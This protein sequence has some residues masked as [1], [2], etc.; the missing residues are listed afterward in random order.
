MST[1]LS[2]KFR[3]LLTKATLLDT[4]TD[5][6]AYDKLQG[7]Y[8]ALQQESEYDDDALDEEDL[9]LP[10]WEN[11]IYSEHGKYGLRAS[12]WTPAVPA[13]Y[14][15][16]ECVD[17]SNV[18]RVIQDG[19]VGMIEVAHEVYEIFKAEYDA[20]TEFA[21]GK[22]IVVKNKEQYYSR[23]GRISPT[24]FDEIRVPVCAGW[25][26]VKKEGIWGYL[27]GNLEF[28][29]SESDAH[30]FL[31][32]CDCLGGEWIQVEDIDFRP[33]TRQD[34]VTCDAEENKLTES[35]AN[36]DE[37]TAYKRRAQV[38]L[39]NHE[40]QVMENDGKYGA[41]DFLGYAVIPPVYDEIVIT[42]H[43]VP[44]IYGKQNGLWAMLHPHDGETI[45][46]SEEL[47]KMVFAENWLI[48]KVKG[49]YGIYNSLGGAWMLAPVYDDFR[50]KERHRCIVTQ[51]GNQYGFF[52][53]EFN[54]PPVYDGVLLGTNLSFV[55]VLKNGAVGYLDAAGEWTDD[56]AKAHVFTKCWEL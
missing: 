5:A 52:D 35:K 28:S 19:K 26:R 54:I 22:Y 33:V 43:A 16:V 27:D 55:R 30:E 25:I 31:I 46:V 17:E 39:P 44:Y 7:E 21:Q 2:D 24:S 45:F 20:I 11:L 32:P 47:P 6:D 41:V 4:C 53:G 29:S 1:T 9:M 38:L 8:L 18:Y 15:S 13:I 49:K 48:A 50:I 51:Q 56:I 23:E 34:I 40:Y 3:A 37:W 42:E 10:N 12:S 14:D 36:Q